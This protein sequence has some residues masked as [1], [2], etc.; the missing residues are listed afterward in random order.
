MKITNKRNIPQTFVN[1]LK[2][3]TYSKGKAHLSVTQLLNSPQIVSLMKKHEDHLEQD[4]SD[5]VWSI[6]GSAVHNIL[7]HG[8]DANHL[9][10]ERLHIE[11]DGR[12]N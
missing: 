5:M 4:A 3:P 9:I 2:R 10:E 6:F 8:K 1:V 7:E 12:G 11:H